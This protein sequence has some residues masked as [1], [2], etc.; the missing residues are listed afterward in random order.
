MNDNS[1]Q[2]RAIATCTT[3]ENSVYSQG[4]ANYIDNQTE[5]WDIVIPGGS[6]MVSLVAVN[7]YGTSEQMN[8]AVVI[9]VGTSGSSTPT[10]SAPPTASAT[11]TAGSASG[12]AASSEC[13]CT[14]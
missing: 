8:L 2:F 9:P 1:F 5:T 7:S 10:A 4:I 13:L 14:N 12:S 11:P 6:Y 3:G